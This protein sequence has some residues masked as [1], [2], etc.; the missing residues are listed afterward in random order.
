MYDFSNFKQ[1]LDQVLDHLTKDIGSL[2]TGK[3]SAAM[4][5]PVKVQAY[6]A[7]MNINEL[8]GIST[9]DANMIIIDPWDKNILSD[10]EKAIEKS[11]LNLHP[12]VDKQIIRITIPSLTEEKR[13]ELVKQLQQKVESAKAMMRSA[14]TDTKGEIEDQEGEAGISEDDIHRDIRELDKVMD[15]YEQ[16]LEEIMDQKKQDLMAIS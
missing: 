8:A 1:K 9:P 2:R 14:R 6:G 4:L 3:A 11:D 13:Q 10:I 5:D 15:E 12:V 16:K 7:T